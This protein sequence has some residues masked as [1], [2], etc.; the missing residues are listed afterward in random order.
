MSTMIRSILV[1]PAAALLLTGC[2]TPRVT[3]AERFAETQTHFG[4]YRDLAAGSYQGIV[5]VSNLLTYGNHGLGT[6]TG[7]DGE[8]IV[9]KD[10]V[11]RADQLG[12]A[13]PADDTQG[14]PF[15]VVTWFQPDRV[16]DVGPMDK[17]L[18][19]RSL[20]LRRA[21][22]R[23]PVAIRV[24][25]QFTRLE[26]R[27][28]GGTQPEGRPLTEALAASARPFTLTNAAGVLVGFYHPDGLEGIHPP[29][30]HLHFLSE[31][32]TRGGH[33]LD[34]TIAAARIELDATPHLQV[35]LNTNLPPETVT[36]PA[37]VKLP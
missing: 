20:L 32:G 26:V 35:F 12:R 30:Y 8:M 37:G 13:A 31:E 3:D 7:L 9:T 19:E 14:V 10:V 24:H 22:G 2:A 6:F 25:G 27:S 36:L 1:F 33:V 17:T 23:V 16:F 5:A 11:Y 21:Q 29:G 28:V 18:F 15:A 4:L 34:F